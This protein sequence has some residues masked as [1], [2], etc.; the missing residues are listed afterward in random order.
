MVDRSKR[1]QLAVCLLMLTSLNA[2]E[3]EEE[4]FLSAASPAALREVRLEEGYTINFNNVSII[5]YIR[6][7]SKIFN[8]NFVFEEADL[9]FSV[10]IVSEDSVSAKNVMSALV[11]ILRVH[12]LTIL[13][14][15]NNLLITK[16][17]DV[18]QIPTIGNGLQGEL[19]PLVTRVFRIKNANI[20]T[21]QNLLRPMMS[22]AALIEASPETRQLIVTDVTTNVEKIATLITILDAPHSPLEIETYTVKHIPINQLINLATQIVAPFS[23]GNPLIMVPQPD[24]NSIFVISTPHLIEKTMQALHDIDVPT[25]SAVTHASLENIFVY[26]IQ[27]RDPEELRKALIRIAETL[28]NQKNPPLR[29][30]DTLMG[31]KTVQPSHSILFMGDS[32]T[33][34]KVKEIL[35]NIDTPLVQTAKANFFIYKIQTAQEEQ[36]RKALLQT[37]DNLAKSD[38]PDK[39]LISAIHT[40]KWIRE[41]NSLVFT[42]DENSLQKLQDLLPQFDVPPGQAASALPP[43]DFFVYTPKVRSGGEIVQA[44]EEIAKNLHE[45]GFADPSLLQ[46]LNTIRWVPITNSLIFTGSAKNLEELKTLLT[47]VDSGEAGVSSFYLY[48]LQ[49]ASGD[50]IIKQLQKVATDLAHSN[51]PNSDALIATTKGVKWI[52]ETNSL[53]IAGNASSV[54]YVKQIVAQLDTGGTAELPTRAPTTFIIYKPQ[55]QS[56]NDLVA[57]LQDF[58]KSL[59][60][61]GVADPGLFDAIDH[62]KWIERTHSLL[63]SGE[64]TSIGKVQDLLQKFD[65]PGTEVGTAMVGSLESTN[66]LVY[67]LQYHQGKEIQDALKQIATDLAHSGPVVNQSLLNAVNSLQWINMTNSLLASGN[68]ETLTKL[69]TL[70]ENLDVPLRQVFIE[71]LVIETNISN[72]QNFGLQW[73]GKAQYMNKFGAGMNNIPSTGT[74]VNNL[75]P[76]LGGVSGTAFPFAPS[77]IPPGIGASPS[78]APTAPTLPGFDL[79]VIGDIILHK[80]RSFISLGSLIN[81]LQQDTDTTIVM[82]PKIIAQDNNNSSIFVG[83]NIPFSSSVVQNTATPGTVTT[84]NVEYR[85]VGVNLSITPILGNGDVITMTI[86]NDITQQTNNQLALTAVGATVT[87]L[88]TTHTNMNTRVHVPDKHFLVLSGMIQDSTNHFKSSIPCLGGLPLIGAAFGTN[89]RARSKNNIV[90]FIRPHIIN[91]FADYSEIT[92]HQENLY[93]ENAF[94]PAVQEAFEAGIDLVKTPEDEY[95]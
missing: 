24:T 1:W 77:D 41:T 86:Q 51:I 19:A 68:Q 6:F 25:E 11:Q 16:S 45:T 74:G 42:G 2:V 28:K 26:K 29:L 85:D 39:D 30:I 40:M 15:D 83:Q 5:E 90:I 44:M 22:K 55:Y 23:Q 84:V 75:I 89:N 8:I 9:Q 87:G 50:D 82:N 78:G 46:T 91:S 49:H 34:G 33:L 62:L 56:G 69:R 70:I 27:N 63:I 61:S 60:Q 80:G 3:I 58:K 79:G 65:V 73:G 66:F 20:V 53:I 17:T 10:T 72:M 43:T 4:N 35:I 37:A 47:V 59:V 32:D 92:D 31:A 54:E 7:V 57:I 52:K 21:L 64:A 88:Q 18:N 13:E 12:N 71:V 14:Q 81:A 94:L 36:I 67:K 48:K 95:R 38:H 76:A 93:E